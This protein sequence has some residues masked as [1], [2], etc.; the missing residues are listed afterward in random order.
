MENGKVAV[1]HEEQL[2]EEAKKTIDQEADDVSKK[3]KI[4]NNEVEAEEEE[5]EEDDEVVPSTTPEPAG[6]QDESTEI[7]VNISRS[8]SPGQVDVPVKEVNKSEKQEDNETVVSSSDSITNKKRELEDED[9]D[10]QASGSN[11]QT[12]KMKIHEPNDTPPV[13]NKELSASVDV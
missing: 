9:G 11:E 13:E 8:I 7:E 6:E 2:C 5:E 3:T 1:E 4:A 10:D 12:K